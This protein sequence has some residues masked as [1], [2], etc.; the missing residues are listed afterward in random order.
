MLGTYT[1]AKHVSGRDTKHLK[2]K[3]KKLNLSSMFYGV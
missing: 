1:Y 3:K 2:K